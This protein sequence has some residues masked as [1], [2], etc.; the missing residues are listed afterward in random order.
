VIFTTLLTNVLIIIIFL[1]IIIS[2]IYQLYNTLIRGHAPFV[3]SRRQALKTIV[4]NLK[5]SDNQIFYE[6]G[7]GGAPLLRRLAPLYPKTNF[8][9]IEY[10]FTPWLL[11]TLL[12]LPY[13]NIKIIK[14]DFWHTDLS[15]ADY[16]YCFL[17]VRVMADLEKK[18]TQETKNTANIIS[19]IFKLPNTMPNKIIAT[20]QEKIYFYKINKS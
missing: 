16:I 3:F 8:V 14:Q 19:Y 17:N 1:I 18:L 2:G 10:A 9:G 13:R 4:A 5:L 20:G 11:G 6:L 12:C 15:P 7:S